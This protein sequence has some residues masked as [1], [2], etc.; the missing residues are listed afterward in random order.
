MPVEIVKPTS[1]PSGELLE[2]CDRAAAQ[3]GWRPV[4]TGGRA[5]SYKTPFHLLYDWGHF[6][7]LAV[8]PL[9]NAGSLLTIRVELTGIQVVDFGEG[10]R[11]ARKFYALLDMPEG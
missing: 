8:Q 11:L 9:E 4:E 6:I 7:E 10:S 2:R 3:L 5:R 1:V